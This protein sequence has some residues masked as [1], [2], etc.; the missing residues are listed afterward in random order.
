MS[1]FCDYLRITYRYEPPGNPSRTIPLPTTATA[2]S[3]VI[4]LCSPFASRPTSR[5]VYPAGV[6]GVT[7]DAVG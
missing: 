6:M 1:D 2:A 4:L 3:S 5:E 7:T